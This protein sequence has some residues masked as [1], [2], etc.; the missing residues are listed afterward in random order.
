MT[1]REDILAKVKKCLDLAKSANEH[2]AA[3]AMRQARK[4]MDLHALNDTEVLA[5][6]AGQSKANSA[7]EATPTAWEDALAGRL[8][9]AF[10]CRVVFQPGFFDRRAQWL[11]I[12]IPPNHEI[13][14]Y[15][16]DV[17]YRQLRKARTDFIGAK[18]KRFKR[19]NKTRRADLFCGAWVYAA[20]AQLTMPSISEAER[21]VIDAYMK[22]KFHNLGELKS[23][24]RNAGRP[25]DDKDFAAIAAGDDA[26]RSAE[27]NRGVGAAA[28]PRMLEMS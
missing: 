17:L 26:G 28:A 5:A 15:S 8:G 22:T 7:V 6:G 18:L 12:G 20:C 16:F 23:V 25:R 13:A 9:R 1:S 19:S 24:D 21:S 3:A 11:F 14:A 2:E 4:L 10:G 27:L